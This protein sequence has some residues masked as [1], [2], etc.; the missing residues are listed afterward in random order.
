MNK[1]ILLNAQA[2]TSPSGEDGYLFDVWVIRPRETDDSYDEI[3]CL[4]EEMI[5]GVGS[6]LEDAVESAGFDIAEQYGEKLDHI[7]VRYEETS[8]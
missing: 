1:Y 7:T 6:T 4:G 8:K 2:T 3:I 5:F